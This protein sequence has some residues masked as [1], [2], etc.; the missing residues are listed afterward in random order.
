MRRYPVPDGTPVLLYHDVVRHRPTTP[1]QVRVDTLAADLDA[2]VA[3]GRAAMTASELDSALA[4]PAA[5]PAPPRCAVTFDDG[6]ASFVDLALPLLVERSLPV[7]LYVT[8]ATL[9][10][11]GMLSGSAV[12]DLPGPRVEIGGHAVRHRH[13]DVLGSA[14][15]EREIRGSREWLADLL[16]WAP[17]S[18]AYPHGSY[19]RTVRNLVRDAGYHNAYA[20]KNAFTHPQDDRYARARLTVLA[21]TGRDVV[22]AWLAGTGAPRAWRRERLRTKVYRPVRAVRTRLS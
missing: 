21:D 4:G 9:G 14:T 8:T 18:F 15:A 11:S 17:P 2:V 3:S 19:N 10:E 5:G 12:V 16:G 1:W 20:V 7:T 22:Q 6:Y 13:L